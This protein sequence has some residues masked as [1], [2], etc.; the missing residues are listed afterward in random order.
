LTT[1]PFEVSAFARNRTCVEFFITVT[2]SA[3]LMVKSISI[4]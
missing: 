3:L 2:D 4:A 1:K